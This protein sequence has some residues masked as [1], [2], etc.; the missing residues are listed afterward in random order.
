MFGTIRAA[1]IPHGTSGGSIGWSTGF[2]D[3]GGCS[4]RDEGALGGTDGRGVSGGIGMAG[5][6]S[7]GGGLG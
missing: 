7:V 4:G 2:S 6:G 5:S 1:G 3:S